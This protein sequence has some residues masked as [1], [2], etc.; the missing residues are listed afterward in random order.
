MIKGFAMLGIG[1]VGIIEKEHL[2]CVVP[3]RQKL[4]CGPH[5]ALVRPIAVAPCTSDLHTCYEGGIGE[6]TDMFLGHEGVGEVVEVGNL[7]KDFKPGDRVIIPAITPNW[8][9]SGAQRG[10]P[11]HEE[12]PLAGWKFSNF[13]DGVF[14]EKIHINDAD[15]NL[16]HLPEGVDPSEAVML[17]D[18]VTTGFHCAESADIKPGDRVAVVG[19]GP[20]GLM[21][22]AGANLMGA[23]EIYAV[24][25]VP[26][27]YEVAH[28]HYGATHF[29]DFSKAPMQEQ[30]MELTKGKGADKI[31]IAG[32]GT[33]VL[34]D[35]CACVINGG[36]VS[37]VNY[38]GSGDYLRV[39]RL[40]WDVGMGHKTIKGGL[41]P[42]GRYRMEKLARLL[43][44]KKLD[45]KPI[46]T[47]RL[48]GKFEEVAQALAWM[49]DKP[50]NFIKPVVKI[51]W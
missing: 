31:L 50:A 23:S 29:I 45:V 7:V 3:V 20:V 14:A 25:C 17:S 30:I 6:R 24:D 12:A 34:S 2:E 5:D 47:H 21:A 41:T 40:H 38:F 22:L 19:L 32:G 13:K 8:S 48:E 37:N 44:T 15:G 49:K 10:Y 36:V 26:F 39:S 27:R 35:A 4:E 28:K 9:S 33:D 51:K 46:I 16:G 42:G 43:Q 1:K 18:M 11:Q